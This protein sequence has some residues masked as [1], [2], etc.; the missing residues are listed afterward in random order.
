WVPAPHMTPAV[1]QPGADPAAAHPPAARPP[2]PPKPARRGRAVM[3]WVGRALGV[4]AAVA[5]L[6]GAAWAYHLQQ[7]KKANAAAQAKT[8]PKAARVERVGDDTLSVPPAVAASLGIRTAA[9]TSADQP[10]PLPPLQ[11][12]LALDNSRLTRVYSPF[13]GLVVALGT[14]DKGE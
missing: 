12:T 6:A 11:G 3:A 5:A 13:P 10:R 9:A 4:L 8:G 14:T 1:H 2:E 7:E